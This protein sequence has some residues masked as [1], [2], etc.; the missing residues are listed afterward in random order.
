[1]ANKEN[2]QKLDL[3]TEEDIKIIKSDPEGLANYVIRNKVRSS[4]KTMIIITLILTAASFA[5]GAF[6]GSGWTREAI[7]NNVVQIKIGDEAA[8]VDLTTDAEGK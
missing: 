1:M 4:R 6:V 5:L 3:L 2:K 7:P 8:N